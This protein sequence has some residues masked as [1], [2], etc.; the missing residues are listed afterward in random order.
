MVSE[1]M[2]L[3][4]PQQRGENGL[5]SQMVFQDESLQYSC[6]G[7]STP[8]RRVG[9]PGRKPRA[10]AAGGFMDEKL[11]DVDA[12][13]RYFRAQG[14]ELRRSVYEPRDRPEN[15]DWNA[16]GST[17]TPSGDGSE[18]DEVDEEDEDEEEDDDV[19]E[20][21]GEV[22]GLVAA[23]DGNKNN[24]SSGSVQ[25]SSEKIRNEKANLHKQHS[26]F[27]L[28]RGIFVKDGGGIVHSTSNIRGSLS[29]HQHQHGRMG[30]YENAITLTEPDIYYTQML[31]G[32]DG[33]GLSQKEIGGENGCGFSGRKDMALSIES[34]ESLRAILSDPIMGTLMDDAIILS[35]GHSFGSGGLQHVLRM[36]ACCTCGQLMTEDF[37]APNLE[38]Y[39]LLPPLRSAVQAFRREEELHSSKA[40]KRRRDRFE[41]DKCSYGDPFPMDFS[42]G[43]GVQFPFAV[44][45]RVIIKG[46]KR[47]PERFVGREAVVTTQCLNGWYV[48]KTLDNAESVKLQYRSLAKVPDN[49]SSNMISEGCETERIMGPTW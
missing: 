18:G 29:E 33:S 41:Q 35:C 17:G 31:Q 2:D 48:V 20:G 28:G 16:E 15:Q 24:N 11:F 23:D 34:G 13:E 10:E 36:K 21:D 40:S 39:D 38:Q 12:R 1:S 43:K 19:D 22:E 45:D 46:N 8:H 14:A 42:R 5:N 49:P 6:G 7:T 3:V 37:V 25:S 4:P 44:T 9:D 27:G 47:T 26:S 30:H 32:Q